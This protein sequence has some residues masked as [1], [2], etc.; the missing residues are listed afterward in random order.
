[1]VEIKKEGKILWLHE[2]KP[3][4]THDVIHGIQEIEGG[5]LALGSEVRH[6]SFIQW[7]AMNIILIIYKNH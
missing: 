2:M 7:F 6:V 5:V 1:M 3:L 4:E